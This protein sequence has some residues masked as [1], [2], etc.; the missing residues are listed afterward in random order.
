MS[1]P[2]FLD[3]N[4]LVYA[5]DPADRDKQ[6]AARKLVAAALGGAAVISVQVLAELSATLL[7]KASPPL[8]PEQVGAILEAIAPIPLVTP[9]HELVRRA[10]EAKAEYGIHFYDGMIVAAA[11][12]AGCA[13]IWSEDLNPGQAYFGIRVENPFA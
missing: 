9:D 6:R 10:I 3:T 4:V 7:H 5:Y 1:A 13:R 12:R 8:R 11:E 2:D